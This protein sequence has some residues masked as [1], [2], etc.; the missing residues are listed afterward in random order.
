[1]GCT[2]RPGPQTRGQKRW[3]R[4]RPSCR[5][6]RIRSGSDRRFRGLDLYHE[7]L[8]AGERQYKSKQLK[9]A[10]WSRTWP[11][12]AWIKEAAA[13]EAILLT[14]RV[15]SGSNR[16]ST[17]PYF[18]TFSLRNPANR[19]TTQGSCQRQFRTVERPGPQTRRRTRRRRATPSCG[20]GA[21]GATKCVVHTS[22]RGVHTEQCVVS[23]FVSA[24]HTI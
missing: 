18:S 2:P 13:R 7:S 20:E 12:D 23:A 3:R 16:L 11:A 14:R 24:A 21:P 6:G 15:R 1:M 5:A 8:D 10:I 22:K 17:P 19:G 9:R 4:A